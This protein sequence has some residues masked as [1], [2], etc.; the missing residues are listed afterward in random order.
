MS[1]PNGSKRITALIVTAV[2]LVASILG[3]VAMAGRLAQVRE[4]REAIKENTQAIQRLTVVVA[5]L[6]QRMESLR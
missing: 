3:N 1:E 4:D 6:E 5:R 2:L